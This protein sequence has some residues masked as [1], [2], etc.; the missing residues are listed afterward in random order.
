[1]HI[2]ESSTATPVFPVLW[3]NPLF[4]VP[5]DGCMISSMFIFFHTACAPQC[6]LMKCNSQLTGH[7]TAGTTRLKVMHQV[8]HMSYSGNGKLRGVIVEPLVTPQH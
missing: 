8:I 6:E 1:M 7:A 4:E 2:A 5:L 3:L